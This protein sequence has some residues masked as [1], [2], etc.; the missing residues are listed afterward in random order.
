MAGGYPGK[1]GI[2]REYHLSPPVNVIGE[3]IGDNEIYLKTLK[4]TPFTFNITG[5]RP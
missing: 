5:A 2:Y 1:G 4:M 3:G